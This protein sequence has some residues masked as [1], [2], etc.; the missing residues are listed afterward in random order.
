MRAGELEGMRVV[1]LQRGSGF[2]RHVESIYAAA[3]LAFRPAVEV[4]NLSLVRRFVAAGLG[5]A[6]VPA[7]AFSPR[8]RFR[9]V[10]TLRLAGASPVTYFRAVR[11]GAPL[12]E[13]ARLLLDLLAD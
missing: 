4:G 12:P 11:A 8:D 1:T 13:A 10:R 9:G 5:W 3:G 2:R 7:V 6:P